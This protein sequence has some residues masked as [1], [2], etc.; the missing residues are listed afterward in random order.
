MTNKK[1]Y[2]KKF[3]TRE[4]MMKYFFTLKKDAKILWVDH[5]FD[6]KAGS[7]VCEWVYK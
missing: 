5:W 3:S 1:V 6:G 4:L 2:S 7:Y